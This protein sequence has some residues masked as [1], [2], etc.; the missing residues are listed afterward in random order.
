MCCKCD[1]G[2][3]VKHA[4]RQGLEMAQDRQ[5]GRKP[6]WRLRVCT[7]CD[8]NRKKKD[9]EPPKQ[10]WNRDVNAALNIRNIAISWM[11]DGVRPLKLRL[12]VADEQA[13]L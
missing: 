10:F 1:G 3:L 13:E 2:E 8:K 9:R 5:S 4:D 6:L 11:K 7:N 12:P